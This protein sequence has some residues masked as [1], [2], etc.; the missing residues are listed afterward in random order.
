MAHTAEPLRTRSVRRASGLLETAFL[1]TGLPGPAMGGP[2]DGNPLSW[3]K[4]Q[5]TTP[6][7]RTS[8]YAYRDSHS[9]CAAFRFT[10][11]LSPSANFMASPYFSNGL[12]AL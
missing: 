2:M 5:T 3:H 6:V 10:G 8:S 4:S 9:I 1:E 11:L 12:S 7:A